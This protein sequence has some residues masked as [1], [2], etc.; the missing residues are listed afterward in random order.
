MSSQAAVSPAGPAPMI[1][2]SSRS[3]S[4]VKGPTAYQRGNAVQQSSLRIGRGLVERAFAADLVHLHQGV[5]ET[6][7][8]VRLV[9][10]DQAHAPGEG[11]APAASDAAGD[12]RVEDRALLHPQAR[13]HGHADG[14]EHLLLVAAAG[15]PPHLPA[16]PPPG[17]PGDPHP[18]LAPLLSDPVDA[19][20]P[21]SGSSLWRGPGSQLH[22]R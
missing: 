9:H 16:T 18:L 14:A 5:P 3:A 12:Q 7:D 1:T 20:V 4:M 13:H 22:L 15:P 6:L 2:T 10:P 8:P 17:L 21:G 19:G 11:V